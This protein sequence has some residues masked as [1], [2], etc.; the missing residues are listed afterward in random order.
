[1][2]A[3]PPT[4]AAGRY[5]LTRVLGE[6]GMGRVWEAHDALLGRDVAIKEMLPPRG[7]DHEQYELLRIRVLREA[8]AIA[9]IDHPNVVRVIDVLHEHGEPWIV[10]DLIPSRSLFAAI[11]RDGPMAPERVAEIGLAV[12]AA[13]RAAHAAGLLH[14][15][16]KPANVLLGFDGRVVLTDF[17]L[18]LVSGDSS[19]TS[20]GVVLGSPSYMAPEHA[21]DLPVGPAAD[22]WSLGATLYA[23]VEGR[24][25]YSKSS[26]VATLAALAG[27]EPPSPPVRAGALRP[28]LD[29]LL[30]KDPARRAD[31]ETT[32]RML[33]AVAA[34]HFVP[35]AAAGER[36]WARSVVVTVAAIAVVL[37]VTAGFIARERVRSTAEASSVPTPATSDHVAAPLPSATRPSRPASTQPQSSR[38][39]V[40]S[41]SPASPSRTTRQPANPAGIDPAT[42][43]RLVN[44]NS[45]KCV[46]VRGDDPAD[47]APVQQLTCGTTKGQHFRLIPT[48][49]GNVRIASR[50]DSL[51]SLDVTD[52]APNDGA[53]IQLWPYNGRQQWRAVPDSNG[54]VHFVNEFSD[55]CLDVPSGS[56]GDGVQLDQFSCNGTPAQAF[57]LE[58][59]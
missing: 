50:L 35:E 1:M 45:G 23:A 52:Q 18:A 41:S 53:T 21:L 24:P 47:H 57:R 33:R 30:E 11:Q 7:I 2:S 58:T 40:P 26:P 3:S 14:R 39:T 42:W 46:D 5:R 54:S 15:D 38:S 49:D 28:V 12:L 37:A 25:P 44:L 56:T 27:D 10:M 29:A 51:K 36:R 43:F 9:R 4:L 17:G 6:G 48:G 34:G 20:T 32:D 55:K 59:A 13:L 8:R 31:A 22:L 19:M 16:V